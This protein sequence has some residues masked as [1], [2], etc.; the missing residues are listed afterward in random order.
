MQEDYTEFF[1]EGP[2]KAEFASTNQYDRI[3]LLIIEDALPIYAVNG[4]AAYKADY[5]AKTQKG[6]PVDNFLDKKVMSRMRS[7]K[8]DVMPTLKSSN[9]LELWVYGI[10]FG[11]I[12][13]DEATQQYW[14]KSKKLGAPTKGFRYD[15]GTQRDVAFSN[16]TA[17]GLD[18]EVEEN[19]N[20]EIAKNGR[21]PI[22]EKIEQVK[23][24]GN[25]FPDLCQM[26][27]SEISN[28]DNPKYTDIK[29]LIDK[30][31]LFIS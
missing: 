31:I 27:V 17:S 18:K 15:M 8:F 10:I 22:D 9:I 13:F 28:I 3:F 19:L 4:F 11:Y 21:A 25:Y 7:E 16:F 6:Y 23:A 24:D 20:K 30:E 12:H 2:D 5:E 26:S 29:K 1:D 14:I